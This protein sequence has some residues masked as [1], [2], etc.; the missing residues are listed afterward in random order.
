M[1]SQRRPDFW[2]STWCVALLV[3]A[4]TVGLHIYFLLHAGGLWRDEVHLINLAG[5]G[6]SSSLSQDSFP[7]LMPMLIHAWEIIGLGR[8]DVGLRLLG[9]LIGLGLPAAL[10]LVAWRFRRSPPLPGLALLALNGTT[11]VFGDSLRAHGLGGLLILLTTA[12]ACWFLEKPSWWRAGGWT[13]LAVL[14]VQ[15]LFHNAIFVAAICIGSWA[16]CARRKDGQAA[17]KTFFVGL[18]AA[19]SLLPYTSNFNSLN[20]EAASLRTG[21]EPG[22]FRAML[23]TAFGFPMEQC[24]WLWLVFALATLGIGGAA[25]FFHRGLATGFSSGVNRPPLRRTMLIVALVTATV[26]L[27]FAACPEN[28]WWI[29][30]PLSAAVVWLERKYF[31]AVGL[32]TDFS[33][34]A[35][36]DHP[37]FAGVSILVASIGFAGFLLYAALPTEAWYYIP[38][39]AMAAVCFEIGLPVHGHVRAAVFGLS[40]LTVLVSGGVIFA[41]QNAVN[42]RFTNV[43]LLCPRLAAEAEAGDLVIV[44]PWYCGLTFQR[45]FHGAAQW[46][47]APPLSDH[48]LARYDLI[49]KQMKNALAMQPLIEKSAETLRAGHRVWLVGMMDIPTPG[50]PLPADMPPPPLP[51]SGWADRPYTSTWVLQVN[52]FLSNHSREFK[53]VFETPEKHLNFMEN[54]QLYRV[55]GWHD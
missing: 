47:T 19:G 41:D 28:H 11:I 26:F 44:S 14:S 42:W 32:K 54:L 39:M 51:Y 25:I 12:A 46:E 23:A 13:V 31:P 35:A 7:V 21:I 27:W 22:R 34:G 45:Y 24:C 3:T 2:L 33:E 29:C 15:V 17:L 40:A 53:L 43:D 37:L 50:V 49:R 55:E 4:V 9:L 20:V 16:V 30:L 52:Q 10:W 1:N 38:L 8:T 5:Q 48:S 6:A 18:T 36:G